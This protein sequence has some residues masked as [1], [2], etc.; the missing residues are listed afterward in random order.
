[1]TMHDLTAAIGSAAPALDA[2]APSGASINSS[3]GVFTWTPSNTQTF[4]LYTLTAR[5]TDTGS[6]PMSDAQTF[7]ITLLTNMTAAAVTLIPTGGI[8]RYLDTGF[9]QG[10]N[11]RGS[12]FNDASWSSGAGVL[13]YGIGGE[14]TT[15]GYGPNPSNKFITTYFRRAVY[16]PDP[17]LVLGLTAR[18]ARDD[19][20]VVYFN[21]TEVWRDNL[22]PGAVA[23]GTLA[24]TALSG[25][26][27]TQFIATAISP[28]VLV[29]GTN[30]IA[31]EIHQDSV[32]TPDARFDFELVAQALVP[33]SSEL[34]VRPTAGGTLL[35]WPETAGLFRV[36]AATNLSLPVSWVPTT[37]APLLSTGQWT[38]LFPATTN[39]ARF[40]R[41]QTP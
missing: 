17:S 37:N 15:L 3:S 16:I 27:Q 20:A 18:L 22:P 7:T 11:W 14:T 4:G 40:F 23:F 19:G 32:T 2:G 33:S 8:W 10:S 5:V 25:S 29:S 36:F 34:S 35:A 12:S 6:P 38:V 30:I 28:S 9:D 26:S 21:N 1:M 31:V 39:G 13:G 41:L 24:S